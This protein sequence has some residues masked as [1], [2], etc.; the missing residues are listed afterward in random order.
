MTLSLA[1]TVVEV[2]SI[3]TIVYF[4]ALNSVYLMTSLFAFGFLRRYSRKLRAVDIEDLLEAAGAP[5]VTLIS[6]AHNEQETI[7]ASVNACLTLKYPEYEIIVVDDGSTDLTLS[8]LT[9]SFDLISAA[10]TPT[11]PIPTAE[12]RAIYSSRRHPNLRVIT[13]DNGGK[14]DALNAGINHCRTPLFC[15][16]DADTLVERDALLKIVRPFLEDN[17]TI[18]VGGTVRI[19]NG[20]SIRGG[21]VTDVRLPKKLLPRFQVME[22]LRAFLS[23]RVGWAALNATLIVSGAFGIFSRKAVVMAGGYASSY[24]SGATVGE[25][26]EL[27]VRLHRVH[28]EKNIP[29]RISFVSDPVAWTECPTTMAILR[30]QRNRWQRG[31][32]ETLS[33]HRVMLLNPRYG[34]IGLLAFPYFYFLE[35]LGPL[36]E[37]LGYVLFVLLLILGWASGN[38]VIAFLIVAFCTGITLSI[39][40]VG[41]EEMTFRRYSRFR[42]LVGLMSLAVLENFGFRQISAWWRVRGIFSALRGMRGWGR[43]ERQG[44]AKSS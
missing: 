35:M 8:R 10:H 42:D 15:A 30:E 39:A 6:P 14:A 32:V 40:A 29:Y 13:K 23:G 37:I 9:E 33:R 18:A 43:M 25:D 17:R 41:L 21:V 24:T 3:V 7:V 12:V 22:Y 36:V 19:V 26:M 38:Y 28:R 11:A 2:F 20:C 27:I 34:R 1:R 16:M 4:V 31:L 44:F 5:P